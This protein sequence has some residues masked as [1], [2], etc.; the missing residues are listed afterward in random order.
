MNIG[1]FVLPNK[2]SSMAAVLKMPHQ[3]KGL[4]I[5]YWGNMLPYGSK[6]NWNKNNL[7]NNT[8]QNDRPKH[9]LMNRP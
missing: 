9:W 3:R 6:L 7:Y 5:D 4:Q 1:S 2:Q 8:K